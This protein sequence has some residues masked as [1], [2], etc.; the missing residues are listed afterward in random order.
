MVQNIVLSFAVVIFQ[1]SLFASIF[2]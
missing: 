1:L 2:Y